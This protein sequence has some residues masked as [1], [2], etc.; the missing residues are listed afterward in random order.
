MQHFKTVLGDIQESELGIILPHEHICC[1]FEYFYEILKRDYLDKEKLIKKSAGHLR[2]MKDM[3]NLST[4]IDCTPI[5][6]G[7]DI[8][9]LRNVSEQ[10]GVNII[11]SSGFYYTDEAMLYKISEEYIADVILKDINKI[12]AGIIKFAVEANEM[13]EL[14]QK[15]LAALCTAQKHSALPLVIHT[16]G[17]NKN[18]KEVLNAALKK[19]IL[20][21]AIT[22]G[23]L[24]DSDDMNYVTEILKSGCYAGFDRIYKSKEMSYYSRKAKDIYTLCERGFADKVLLSH[25]AITFNGFHTN[26]PLREDNPYESI[27]RYLIPEMRKIGFTEKEINTLIT[28]NP[29]NMLLCK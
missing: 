27:F 29:R 23:H 4:L 15:L 12:N 26:A 18:G 2:Q 1:Y 10:S 7:R 19:G 22:I 25:D 11:C 20:P 9:I 17:K 13:N 16:N 28:Q 14:S 3:Y 21:N 8:G 6:I 5:N 24:S